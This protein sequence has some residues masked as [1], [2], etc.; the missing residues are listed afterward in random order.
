MSAWLNALR[1]RHAKEFAILQKHAKEAVL[2][3]ERQE[4]YRSS[5]QSDLER[6]ERERREE[7]E[8]AAHEAEEE[9]RLEA[10]AKRR[11]E[12]LESL[13]EEP[14]KDGTLDVVTIALRFADGKQSGGQRRFLSSTPMGTVF[15]WVDAMF[16]MERETITLT[17]MNGQSSFEWE[18]HADTTLQEAGIGRMTGL[19]VLHK[20][21][22]ETK[23]E[24]ETQQVPSQ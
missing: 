19:R 15:N 11:K 9:R 8:R 23:E 21:K 16:E 17:T 10:I 22:E 20:K 7:I 6:Q 18:E 13:P 1:K 12:L 3:Q 4:G 14:P 2:F 5:V 24:E